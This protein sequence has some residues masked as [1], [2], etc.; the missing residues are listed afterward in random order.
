MLI[1][2]A[3]N[4]GGQGKTLTA[5]LLTKYLASNPQYQGKIICC[6]LDKTQQN[7]LDNMKDSGLPF[8]TDINTIP[9]DLV[10]VVDT[11]PSLDSSLIEAIK[12]ADRLV[13]PIVLGKHSVQGVLRIA[14]LRGNVKDMRILINEWDASAAQKEAEAHLIKAGFA[15]IGK[16]PRYKRLAYNID[17]GIDWF[18]GFPETHVEKIIK[19]LNGLLVKKV[20]A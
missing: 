1:V 11:P 18:Y 15:I 7:F 16:I 10:G 9:S 2:V 12:K 6:D 20:T 8:V 19:I 5:T 13:V 14:E 17:L 4:K 3:N